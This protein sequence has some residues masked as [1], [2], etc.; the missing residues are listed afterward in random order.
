MKKNILF[1]A[2]AAVL[3]LASCHSTDSAYKKAYEKA[4]AQEAAQQ[5]ASQQDSPVV[6]PVETTPVATAPTK[7]QKTAD[8]SVT[9]EK[10]TV[11]GGSALKAYSVVVGAFGLKTNAE[12]VQ[13]T[14]KNKGYNG[15]VIVRNEE[16]NLYRVVAA[17]FD[18]KD[19]AVNSRN[20]LRSLFPDAWLLLSE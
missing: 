12:G 19:E 2:A 6:A 11:V 3:T 17:T 20:Q 13:Q 5:A 9:R 8:V 16:R 14:L 7:S 1:V 4:R 18:S 15:A 10:L